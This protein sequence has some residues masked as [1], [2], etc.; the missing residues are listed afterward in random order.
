MSSDTPIPLHEI[1]SHAD[2]LRRLVHD[3]VRDPGRA[4]DVLQETWLRAVER[5]PARGGSLRGWLARVARNA[6]ID[7]FRQDRQRTARER[8]RIRP[9]PARP[10]IDS[11]AGPLKESF[12]RPIQLNFDQTTLRDAL[13]FISSFTGTYIYP[14]EGG[15]LEF[16]VYEPQAAVK[17]RRSGADLMKETG[18]ELWEEMQVR[19]SFRSAEDLLARRFTLSPSTKIEDLDGLYWAMQ[20]EVR[21]PLSIHLADSVRKLECVTVLREGTAG[22]ILRAALG[23][24]RGGRLAATRRGIELLPR[25]L[26]A[27][28]EEDSRAAR[29]AIER[30]GKLEIEDAPGTVYLSDLGGLVLKTSG[31]PVHIASKFRG[32]EVEI[33]KGT[34]CRE[35]LDAVIE[36]F[37]RLGWT[38]VSGV[39][40]V[41][42][43]SPPPQ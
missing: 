1:L 34:T 15:G 38:V 28:A 3:L 7:A 22:D 23:P 17:D 29:A 18:R 19:E 10:T 33:P 31:L 32:R 27:A 30:L 21:P 24:I 42:P 6:S 35:A 2:W 9:G 11:V 5:P 12:R 13:T 4:D 37:P 40:V 16:R 39:V 36:A 14:V 20:R 8:R 43:L 25:A 26:A 41:L